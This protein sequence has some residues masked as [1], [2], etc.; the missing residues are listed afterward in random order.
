MMPDNHSA[1]HRQTCPFVVK[2]ASDRTN[3][4]AYYIADEPTFPLQEAS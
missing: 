4:S 1:C 3:L 2:L